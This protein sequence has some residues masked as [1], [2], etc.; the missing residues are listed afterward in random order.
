MGERPIPEYSKPFMDTVHMVDFVVPPVV[1]GM[2]YL[3]KRKHDNS[4]SD[5]N[6]EE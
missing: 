2:T 1:L 4:H 5:D 6:S 3:A